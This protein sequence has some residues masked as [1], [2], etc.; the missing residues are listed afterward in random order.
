MGLRWSRFEQFLFEALFLLVAFVNRFMPVFIRQ[1]GS[2]VLLATC[3]AGSAH[4]RRW[5]DGAAS[6]AEP[7]G[8]RRGDDRN[9]DVAGDPVPAHRL[10]WAFFDA[11]QVQLIDTALRTRIPAGSDIG[12]AFLLTAAFWPARL[13][14]IEL[15]VA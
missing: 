8:Q 2:Y 11:E 10:V 6:P 4:T 9:G 5:C 12:G 14:G 13:L 15:C 1:G 3:G 7:P